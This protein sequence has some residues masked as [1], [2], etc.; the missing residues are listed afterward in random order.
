MISNNIVTSDEFL[1][2]KFIVLVN[3]HPFTTFK[4]VNN[5]NFNIRYYAGDEDEL[6]SVNFINDVYVIAN[7]DEKLLKFNFFDN[8]DYIDFLN[9][10]AAPE[11]IRDKLEYI[12]DDHLCNGM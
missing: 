2:F 11:I 5:Q 8:P 9:I 7:D 12:L 4:C 6:P 1:K 3:D 10:D